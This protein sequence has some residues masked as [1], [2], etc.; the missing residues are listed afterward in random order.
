MTD[1]P[2][3]SLLS[4]LAYCQSHAYLFSLYKYKYITIYMVNGPGFSLLSY[5]VYFQYHAYRI[6]CM[7]GI[8]KVH[9]ALHHRISNH[10]KKK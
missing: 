6:F 1:V 3:L 7:K 2:R 10:L 5:L 8:K 4:D 9:S